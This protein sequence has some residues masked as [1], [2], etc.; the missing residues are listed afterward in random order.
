MTIVKLLSN[1]RVHGSNRA[2]EP[3]KKVNP[4]LHLDF[5]ADGTMN[6]WTAIHDVVMGGISSGRLE[7]AGNDGE[8]FVGTGS[9]RTT[10]D[11]LQ[12]EKKSRTA[13]WKAKA[14]S[15]SKQKRQTATSE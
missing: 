1:I 3:S 6:D 8:A 14:G 15:D 12:Y 5:G 4:M 7:R 11:S 10:V 2:A 9:L 13:L